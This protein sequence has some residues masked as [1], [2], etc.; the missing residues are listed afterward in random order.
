MLQRCTDRLGRGGTIEAKYWV[1]TRQEDLATDWANLTPSQRQEF[2]SASSEMFGDE[3]GNAVITF[4]KDIRE[5]T[6]G[7]LHIKQH[8]DD[9]PLNQWRANLI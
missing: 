6:M 4:V 1:T 9:K 3:L 5:T 8:M 2:F 7:Q